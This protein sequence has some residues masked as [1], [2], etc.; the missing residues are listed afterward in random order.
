MAGVVFFFEEY[1]IDVYSGRRIDLDAWNYAIRAAGDIDRII[2]INR[3]N[4]SIKGI[5][6]D[7]TCETET[8]LPVLN[9]SVVFVVCPWDN[10]AG[11]M[12]SL[13]NFN[14]KVDWY[15]FGPSEGWDDKQCKDGIFIP[16]AG[17]GALHALH[18]GAVVMMHRFHVI[19]G[20]V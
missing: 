18:I 16:Q 11:S 1:E 8:A 7:I 14:H 13:W 12:V 20:A 2:I 4:Q 6:G 9:G 19:R 3:T 17:K 10:C 15:V 5:G